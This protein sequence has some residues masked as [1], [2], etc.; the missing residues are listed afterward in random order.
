MR[1]RVLK[2]FLLLEAEY[3]I[4]LSSRVFI[5]NQQFSQLTKIAKDTR[6]FASILYHEN[7]WLR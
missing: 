1:S 2:I 5:S 4:I 6:Y 7:S 3:K